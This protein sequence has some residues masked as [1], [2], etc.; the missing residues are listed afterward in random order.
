VEKRVIREVLTREIERISKRRGIRIRVWTLG[1]EG[2]VF[3]VL[4]RGVGGG[5]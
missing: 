5:K 4:Q 3:G 1:R 2:L